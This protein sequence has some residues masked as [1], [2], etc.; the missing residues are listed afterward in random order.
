MVCSR[1]PKLKKTYHFKEWPLFLSRVSQSIISWYSGYVSWGEHPNKFTPQILPRPTPRP[2]R[3]PPFQQRQFAWVPIQEPPRKKN[4]TFVLE[5]G[6]GNFKTWSNKKTWEEAILRVV[7]FDIMLNL[8]SFND[9]FRTLHVFNN[10][11]LMRFQYEYRNTY[12]HRSI[13]QMQPNEWYGVYVPPLRV[14]SVGLWE[15]DGM[16][17]LM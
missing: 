13:F 3:D 9:F 6:K 5:E 15:V 10:L 2:A 8:N 16:Q 12:L 4:T 14:Q 7:G 11:S 17:K 1:I